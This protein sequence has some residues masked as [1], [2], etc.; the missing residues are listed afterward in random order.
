MGKTLIFLFSLNP[1]FNTF[2]NPRGL[3]ASS[4]GH[5]RWVPSAIVWIAQTPPSCRHPHTPHLD[6]HHC[7]PH[8][9]GLLTCFKV[10][11][12]TS[13]IVS[14]GNMY[15]KINWLLPQ[16]SCWPRQLSPDG[17]RLHGRVRPQQPCPFSQADRGETSKSSATTHHCRA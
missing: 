14:L 7:Q 16:V 17:E 1:T 5:P 15:C 12:P 4:V 9:N 8:I 11:I 3:P 13:S 10:P 2:S 6:R